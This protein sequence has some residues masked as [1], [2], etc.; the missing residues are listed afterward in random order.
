VSDLFAEYELLSR[1]ALFDPAFY[2]SRY[3]AVTHCNQDP[4][5]HYVER[6]GRERLNPS[7]GFNTEHYLKQCEAFGEAPLNPLYH[8]LTVGMTRGMTPSPDSNLLSLD[9]PKLRDGRVEVPLQGGLSIVGWAIA[10]QGVE[11]VDI[12]IDGKRV[13]SAH[14]GLRRPDV[15]TAHPS[16]KGALSSGFAAHLPPKAVP[17]GDHQ[18]GLSLLSRDG[19]VSRIEFT[20]TIAEAPSSTGPA[21]LRR[22]M[23][24]AEVDL[25][26]DLLGR[27]GSQ[28]GF[29]IVLTDSSADR[30]D[31][32]TIAARQTLRTLTRQTYPNWQLVSGDARPRPP[33]TG[34]SKQKTFCLFLA[35]GDELGCDALLEFALASA[36]EPDIALWYSDDRR[37]GADGRVAA[38]FKPGWSPDLLLSFNYLGRAWCVDAAVLTGRLQE[39]AVAGDYERALRLSEGGHRIGHVPKVLQQQSGRCQESPA[40]ERS[41]LVKALERRE[42]R[43]EVVIGQGGS[44]FR[45][46]RQVHSP[47]VSVIIPTCAA[48]GLVKTCLESLRGITTYKNFEVIC[49]E[50]I[51]GKERRW[52]DWLAGRVDSLIS[53]RETFNWA[54]FN[55]LA[56]TRASGELLLFLNDDTQ[57]I[58]GEWLHALIEHAQRPEVATVG[59][60]LLYPDRSVQHGG[61]VLDDAGRGRHAF[62]HLAET[63]PGYFGLAHCIRNVIGST[64]ACLMTRRAVFTELG[65]F[66]EDH[67]VINNDLDY[68]LRAAGKGLLNVYTPYARLI[69][70]E[71]ASR[72][73]VAEAYGSL[74]FHDRW[75]GVIAAGDPYFNPNLSREQDQL[76]VDPEP[77]ETVAAGHPRFARSTIRRILVV[78]LDHI[79]DCVN[80]LPAVRR[81]KRYFPSGHFSVLAGRGTEPVWRAE[82]AVD[83]FIAFDFFHARSGQGKRPVPA[84]EL[85]AMEQQLRSMAFDLAI[86]LR[87]QPDTREV[88]KMTGAEVLIGF[89]TQGRFPWLD[90]ALEW[91]E[92]VPLRTKHGHVADDLVALVEAVGAH[93]DE[94]RLTARESPVVP[95]SLPRA[96]QRRLF[97]LPLVCVHPAAGS[98]MRQWPVEKFAALIELLLDLGD[99]NVALI[100]GPDEKTL[101]E[102]VLAGLERRRQVFNLT[103]RLPLEQL[104]TLLGRAVLF[105]GNNSGPQHLAAAA[106]IP[107]IG[108]HS[109]VVDAREWGPLGPRA[110][111]IRKDVVCAPCFLEFPEHCQRG[112]ACL[113]DLPVGYVYRACLRALGRAPHKRHDSA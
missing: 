108:I 58:D 8:Y 54:R 62:R 22:K 7:P 27:L 66:D 59:A 11:A 60:L 4:L 35:A 84:T 69:H 25:K 90:V 112:L 18:V 43:A 105:V 99:C 75:R 57:I 44:G 39:L 19:Q 76:V 29:H 79:G 61:F 20:V 98:V 100:G 107:T 96:Q 51:P 30:S 48:A 1:S 33:R 47:K 32:S 74:K 101:A 37:I 70:H 68:C 38:L 110:V 50:N 5:M 94:S 55:N 23:P 46:R 36:L 72:A 109:G 2:L 14:H 52:R 64:G 106:G 88:L 13:A 113:R 81:L 97:E 56:V 15:A 85:T 83:E 65:G 45:V 26:L 111:A 21:A 71:L 31:S 82:P 41:A 9:I 17:A 6:G 40:S 24:Q 103:G 93:S 34:R 91:D 95:L 67:V 3:P 78:K 87:K 102:E 80:A 42:V 28:P 10:D 77:L 89:D 49:I 12:A 92:D 16:R 53:T 73:S 104:L 86:D 63:D